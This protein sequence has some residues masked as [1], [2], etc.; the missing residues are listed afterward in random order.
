MF[1][2]DI[3]KSPSLKDDFFKNHQ[4]KEGI[5]IGNDVWIGLGACIMPG[6][7]IGNGVVIAAGS[8]VTKDVLAYTIVGG[9]PAK[10][11]RKKYNEET[12]EKLNKIAWWS[13]EEK[14]IKNKVNDFQLDINQFIKKHHK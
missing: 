1:K 3:K 7:S 2:D 9:V 10:S 13:W 6:V 12:I 11:I 14:E 4:Q 8:I 5:N